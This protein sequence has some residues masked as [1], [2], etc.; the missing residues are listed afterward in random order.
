MSGASN[1]LKQIEQQRMNTAT[2]VTTFKFSKARVRQLK[3]PDEF[4]AESN[5][6]GVLYWMIRD[7]RV[8]DNW[9]FLYA[10]R[11]AL[12]FQV[13]LHACFCLVPCYQ[14]DTLRHFS[15]MI[16]GLTQVE[17]ECRSLNIHFR[18]LNVA[19]GLSPSARSQ[20]SKHRWAEENSQAL[21]PPD[22]YGSQVAEQLKSLVQ[23]L[24]IG[25][26]V[27]DFS[28]LRAPTMWVEHVR[29]QLPPQLPFCQVDAHNIV[30][31]WCGSDKC[32]F[33]AR[34]IR[35]KLYEKTGQFLTEFPPLI[36]HPFSCSAPTCR[37]TVNW[38]KI[39][40]NYWGDCTVQPVDWAQPGTAAAYQVLRSFID[41]R[42]RD[43]DAHRN[44]PANPALSGLSP[45]FHFG[46]MAPQRAVLEVAALQH[47]YGR[48]VDV[49]IEEAFNRRELADNFCFHTP[50]YDR[51]QGARQWAQDTLHKHAE[52]KRDVSFTRAQ[53][54]SSGTADDLWNAAQRQLVQTGKMHGF[55][56][57][58][59]AKKILEWCADGPEVAIQW[60]IYLNDRYSLDGTDP[61]GYVGIMWA[62]CGVHDQGWPE[63]RIFGKVRYMCYNG[64]RRWFSV[65]TFVS[66]F[67]D[68]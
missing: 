25:C 7:Q 31:V 28:P 18:L 27:T 42:L 15:F 55:L 8:Q 43:F 1:W 12:K 63:R 60:A 6:G 23:T 36:K 19:D 47:K 58:Y 2:S 24:N 4:P 21:Q 20:G 14:A 52:D 39:R 11:L 29:T 64:C 13:P 30:P 38:Y 34:T 59:W 35:P 22:L 32:E 56:R 62:I 61:N 51:L 48:S 9:A 40:E 66:R 44:D 57:Q 53:L 65:P 26:I 17:Q 10:Q 49:F 45:W 54:E 16:G 50:L 5:S 68:T 3:G 46:Q 37:K 33:S 67:S 41:E